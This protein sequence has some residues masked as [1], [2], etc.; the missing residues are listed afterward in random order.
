MGI[1]GKSVGLTSPLKE[2]YNGY[3]N[4]QYSYNSYYVVNYL[5]LLILFTQLVTSEKLTVLGLTFAIIITIIANGFIALT[6]QKICAESIAATRRL[7]CGIAT[8]RSCLS[9]Y[10]IRTTCLSHTT[11]IIH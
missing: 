11:K 4:Y 6:N 5:V 1:L 3:Y 10:E 7:T 9:R 2:K 8:G